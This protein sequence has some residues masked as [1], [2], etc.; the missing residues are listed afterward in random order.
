MINMKFAKFV[1]KFNTKMLPDSFNSYFTKLDNAHKHYTWKKH[2]NEYYSINTSS[3]SR[4]KKT[5]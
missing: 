5:S 3:E 2:G 1:F 4:K